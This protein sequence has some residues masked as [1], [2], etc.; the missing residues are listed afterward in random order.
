MSFGNLGLADLGDS[1]KLEA[2]PKLG[3]VARPITRDK[4]SLNSV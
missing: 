2:S 4:T 1:N 3:R